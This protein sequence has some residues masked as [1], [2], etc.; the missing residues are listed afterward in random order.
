MTSPNCTAL[1]QRQQS[2]AS[3]LTV[4]AI[5]LTSLLLASTGFATPPLAAING[6]HTVQLFCSQAVAPEIAIEASS[7][8]SILNEIRSNFQLNASE[9]AQVL[10]VSRPTLYAWLA[11]RSQ[12][13]ASHIHRLYSLRDMSVQWREMIGNRTDVIAQPFGDK[14]QLVETLSMLN[15]DRQEAFE[16]LLSMAQARRAMQPLPSVAD[17]LRQLG[18]AEQSMPEQVRALESHGW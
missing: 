15:I 1:A 6:T 8:R 3:D 7:L 13:R 16:K 14:P 17:R 2:S 10:A 12:P 5:T 11:E 4:P 9:L 18:F